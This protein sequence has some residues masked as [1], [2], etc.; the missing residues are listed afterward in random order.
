MWQRMHKIADENTN[1]TGRHEGRLE[2][3]RVHNWS[4]V[5]LN[6]LYPWV[7]HSWI[8]QISDGKYLEKTNKKQYNN[9]N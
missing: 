9:K 1:V 2:Y 4:S 7:L 5:S 6:S 3:K 8:Q